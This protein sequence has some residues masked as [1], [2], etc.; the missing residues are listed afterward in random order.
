L[1]T[2]PV[3]IFCQT[4]DADRARAFY[5]DLLGFK[6]QAEDAFAPTFFD[7]RFE[8]TSSKDAHRILSFAVDKI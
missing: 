8:V 4:T 1:K 7:R 6:F 3:I 5:R 2:P